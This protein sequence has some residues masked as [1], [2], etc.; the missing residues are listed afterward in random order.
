MKE[1][2]LILDSKTKV[3]IIRGN[4]NSDGRH[5]IYIDVGSIPESEITEYTAKVMK[6]LKENEKDII[7]FEKE[8]SNLINCYSKENMSDTPDFILAEYMHNC[9]IAFSTAVERR[10][11][12]YDPESDEIH[13]EP[14]TDPDGPPCSEEKDDDRTIV[15]QLIGEASMLNQGNRV[16]DSARAIQIVDQILELFVNKENN[17]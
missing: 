3:D 8:L 2:T 9:L 1:E 6:Y 14:C 10:T 12:W 4:K 13:E 5:V 15:T 7:G 11:I 17:E 16:F